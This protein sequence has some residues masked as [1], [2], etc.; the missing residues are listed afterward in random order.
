V[1]TFLAF[2]HDSSILASASHK[3]V[4]LW[5]V[6]NTSRYFLTVPDQD[7]TVTSMAFSQDSNRLAVG[8]YDGAMTIWNMDVEAHVYGDD[9][10]IHSLGSRA[11]KITHL[12]FSPDS[13]ILAAVSRA[14]VEKWDADNEACRDTIQFW[15]MDSAQCMRT[16]DTGRMLGSIRFDDTGTYLHTSVGRFAADAEHVVDLDSE[17]FSPISLRAG[18]TW[19]NYKSRNRLWIPSEY[20]PLYWC[21]SGKVV[22]VGDAIGRVWWCRFR[23]E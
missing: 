13:K 6:E 4:N 1:V 20:R 12:A 16:I 5:D 15:D 22:A 3:T 23:D 17:I 21:I 19:I 14:P 2:S 8:M 11:M 18:G 7:S 10:C 9:A